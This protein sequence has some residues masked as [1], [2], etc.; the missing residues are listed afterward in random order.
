MSNHKS[1]IRHHCR[2]SI[3]RPISNSSRPRTAASSLHSSPSAE[4]PSVETRIKPNENKTL[5]PSSFPSKR[6][7]QSRNSLPSNEG[8]QQ[9]NVPSV[10]ER[11][12]S[13]ANARTSRSRTN[14]RDKVLPDLSIFTNIRLIRSQTSP[15]LG[16]K[17][18]PIPQRQLMRPIDPPTPRTHTL[19]NISCIHHMKSSEGPQQESSNSHPL[20]VSNSLIE[21]GT[22]L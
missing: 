16:Q 4:S 5:P 7:S 17:L 15:T 10:H 13:D 22:P 1:Q 11:L 14:D 9:R 8:Y 19:H 3:P 2:S 20:N 6:V 18:P 21:V 12:F